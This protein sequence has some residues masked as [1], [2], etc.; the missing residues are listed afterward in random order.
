[1]QYPCT[2]S[3]IDFRYVIPYMLLDMSRSYQS[4]RRPSDREGGA[5]VYVNSIDAG[6]QM[7]QTV[8]HC[9]CLHTSNYEMQTTSW[10][11]IHYARCFKKSFT[12]LKGY[13]KL[14]REHVEHFELSQC[15]KTH[16]SFKWDSYGSMWLSLVMQGVSKKRFTMVFWVWLCGEC[17]ENVYTRHTV[18]FG[19]PL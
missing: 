1:M 3:C 10:C 14:F 12:T 9:K 15:S 5:K 8:Q 11:W 4:A 6:Y 18:T 13:I 17:Y 16:P 2:C 7:E 19:I